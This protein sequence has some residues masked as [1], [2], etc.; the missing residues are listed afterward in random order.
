MELRIGGQALRM[1]Q[2]RKRQVLTPFTLPAI[3]T[4]A[5]SRRLKISNDDTRPCWQRG[6]VIPQPAV[7]GIRFLDMNNLKI[8]NPLAKIQN[9]L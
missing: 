7:G 1:N 8:H 9:I 4:T 5:L 6:S 2:H 3:R